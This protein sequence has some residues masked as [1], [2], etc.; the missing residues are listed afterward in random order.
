M[1]AAE[2][3]PLHSVADVIHAERTRQAM[4]AA[5]DTDEK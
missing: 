3:F 2:F 4:F 1:H 5:A